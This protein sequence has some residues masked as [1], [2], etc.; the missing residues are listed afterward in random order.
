V[1]EN[2]LIEL[3]QRIGNEVCDGCGPDTDCGIDPAE[4][5]RIA[6]ALEMLLELNPD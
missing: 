4:C 3:V 5:E 1:D 2:K 6:N